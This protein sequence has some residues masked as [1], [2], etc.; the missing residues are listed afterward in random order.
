MFLLP[1]TYATAQT[2]A[3]IPQGVQSELSQLIGSMREYPVVNGNA[4]QEA[5]STIEMVSFYFTLK[6]DFFGKV[7]D[8]HLRAQQCLQLGKADEAY[9]NFFN[10]SA[11]I[12]TTNDAIAT[13]MVEA[14]TFCGYQLK[15]GYLGFVVTGKNTVSTKEGLIKRLTA[16][17]DILLYTIEVGKKTA[18][19]NEKLK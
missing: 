2:S 4:A 10:K 1:L 11:L 6:S 14:K 7:D 9:S 18:A 13:L 16:I 8:F 3:P 19:E 5:F 17:Q 12:P 15:T